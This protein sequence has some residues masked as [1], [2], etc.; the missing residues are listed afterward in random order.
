MRTPFTNVVFA[1]GG[2][3]CMWQAGF[4]SVVAAERIVEPRK[5][6]AVSAGSAIAAMALAG[7]IEVGVD[8]FVERVAANRRNAYPR[9]AFSARPLFP[10][11][12]IYRSIL[13]EII[14]GETFAQI[15]ARA[16]LHI[17]ISRPPAWSDRIGRVAVAASLP[18]GIAAY[19][20]ERRLLGSLHPRWPSRLGFRKDIVRARDLDGPESLIDAVLASSCT[21]PVTPLYRRDGQPVLDGGLVDNIGVEAMPERSRAG[22]LVLLSKRYPN[23]DQIA[24]R[25][26]TYVQPSADI[27]ILKWDY[28]RPDLVRK[29]FEL[30]MRDGAAFVA[31][32][33]G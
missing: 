28:T 1:G 33:R 19:A 3:R 4:W 27:P 14:D 16:D 20:L 30:G 5:V 15:N 22:A 12:E 6:A 11:G 10:H 9:N 17:L 24:T 13:A 25:S 31:Q 23:L 29:T 32:P 26:V 2:C 7:R 18:L 21:P 8:A